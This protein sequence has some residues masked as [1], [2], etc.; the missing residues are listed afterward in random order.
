MVSC[1][2]GNVG[3]ITFTSIAVI[4]HSIPND[5]IIVGFLPA[6]EKNRMVEREKT[7]RIAYGP[8]LNVTDV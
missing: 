1:I 8:V 2:D 4:N 3:L 5:R 7:I 6:G